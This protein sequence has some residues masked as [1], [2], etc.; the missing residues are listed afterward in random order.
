[1]YILNMKNTILLCWLGNTD[2]KAFSGISD[3]GLGS[4]AQATCSEDYAEIVLLNNWEEKEAQ[5]YILWLE[6]KTQSKIILKQ[7]E[8][9]SLTSFGEIY[10]AACSVIAEKQAE[11]GIDIDFTY[12]LSP[13]ALQQWQQSGFLLQKLNFQHGLLNLLKNMVSALHLSLLI[14]Q[15]ILSLI[16]LENRIK[17]SGS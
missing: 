16:F 13:Q 4:I 11:E 5:K 12:H 10:Q 2:I 14:F 9:S 6:Q 8:L 7:I 15:Q 1:M 3:V 17:L